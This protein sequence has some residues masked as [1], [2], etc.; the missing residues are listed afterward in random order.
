[1]SL[2]EISHLL[3]Q[4]KLADQKIVQIFEENIGISLTRYEIMM[5]LKEENKLMQ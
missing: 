4:I 1:M 3:Y 2:E 5:R